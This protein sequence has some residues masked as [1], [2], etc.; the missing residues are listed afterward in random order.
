MMRTLLF[1]EPGHFHAALTLRAPNPRIAPDVHVYARPGPERDAFLA[2]VAA[3]NARA[4]APTSW[5]VQVHEPADPL[6]TLLEERRGDLVI[7]AGPN[8]GKLATIARLH[9]AGLAVLADKP[10]LTSTDSLADLERVTAGPPLAMDIMT[11]RFDTVARL[12]HALVGCEAFFG[13]LAAPAG[14]E[15]AIELEAVHHLLKVVNGRPL[16]RPPWYFDVDVQGDGLVDIQAHMIDQAQWLVAEDR[17][18]DPEGDVRIEAARRWATPVPLDL[19]REITGEEDFPIPLLARV[20]DG[21]LDLECNGEIESSLAG[22][23]VRQRAQW[24]PREPEGGGDLHRSVVHGTRA[25]IR[26]EQGPE[27]GGV[28]R[29]FVRPRSESGAL[30]RLA[31]ALGTLRGELP[32]LESSVVEDGALEIHVPDG[33][34]T[35]HESHFPRV[36]DRCLDHLDRGAWPEVLGARIRTRY[37]IVA[38]ALRIASNG[39]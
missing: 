29:I 20:R 15:P 38:G 32:G 37:A 27:T 36:L 14:G 24:W 17:L 18:L 9:A 16:R 28:P 10:W 39:K 26:V 7:L 31:A 13:T 8:R 23:P 30:D 22:I 34:R 21:V 2:L 19:F 4:E 5:R 12:R 11:D 33:L 6:A 1:L 25:S 35:A 3:F